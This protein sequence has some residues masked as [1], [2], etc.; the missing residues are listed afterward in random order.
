MVS[1]LGRPNF[2][3][4][5][6][7]AASS[8]VESVTQLVVSPVCSVV[9]VCAGSSFVAVWVAAGLEAWVS[10][11]ELPQATRP[12]ERTSVRAAPMTRDLVLSA[13]FTEL[14]IFIV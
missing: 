2:A 1:W 3:R 8:A 11:L 9:A 6:P 13:V 4:P 5:A 12:P 10:L 7:F 14:F